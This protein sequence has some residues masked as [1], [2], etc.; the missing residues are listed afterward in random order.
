MPIFRSLDHDFPGPFAIMSGQRHSATFSSYSSGQCDVSRSLRVGFRG[1]SDFP[2]K[3]GQSP[4][5]HTSCPSSFAS[6]IWNLVASSG[7]TGAILGC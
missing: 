7:G 6:L 4:G 3:E 5:R 2:D 1:H